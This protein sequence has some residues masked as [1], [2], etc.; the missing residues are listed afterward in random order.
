MLGF[1]CLFL[2]LTIFSLLKPWTIAIPKLVYLLLLLLIF[3]SSLCLHFTLSLPSSCVK[4]TLCMSIFTTATNLLCGLS[5]FFCSLTA[6]TFPSLHYVCQLS[7]S[8]PVPA[9]KAPLLT[10]TLLPFFF[11]AASECTFPVS[12]S[13]TF[14]QH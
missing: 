10:S 8:C 14:N 2:E 9:F 4:P 3:S 5:L 6:S 12:S 7:L 13:S 11:L 1:T